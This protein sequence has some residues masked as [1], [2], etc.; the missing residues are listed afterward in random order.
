MLTKTILQNA[1]IDVVKEGSDGNFICHCPFHDDYHPS[2]SI[3][4]NGLWIC[5]SCGRRG[6]IETLSYLLNKTFPSMDLASIDDVKHKLTPEVSD[7]SKYRVD[8]AVYADTY[9]HKYLASRGISLETARKFSVGYDRLSES[10]VFPF[11]PNAHDVIAYTL[12][13]I[14]DKT[15]VTVGKKSKGFFGQQFLDY[16]KPIVIVEGQIDAM[17]ANMLGFDN[18]VAVGGA[19]LSK[20]QMD[21]ILRFP[22]VVLGFDNDRTGKESNLRYGDTLLRLLPTYVINYKNAKDFGES[23]GD[24][25]I[26]HYVRYRWNV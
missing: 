24:V 2:F 21:I 4:E 17:K 11:K 1:G 22:K 9:D 3:K 23:D 12:R 13:S 25:D 8:C 18:V 20:T 19:T 6:N 5:F 26:I 16:D 14:H 7:E 15:H 10:V